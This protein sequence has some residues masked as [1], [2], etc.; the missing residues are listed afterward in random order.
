V[1]PDRGDDKARTLASPRFREAAGGPAPGRRR[2][3]DVSLAQG[4]Y[5]TGTGLWP[6]VSMSSFERVT[7]PKRD[8][9]LVKTVG[10][11]V[12]AIGMT[13]MRS[14]HR[15]RVHPD[16]ALLAGLSAAALAAIDI[17]N[18]VRRR[19]SPVYLVDALPEAWLAAW[20][21]RRVAWRGRVVPRAPVQASRKEGSAT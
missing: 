4:L 11:L 3:G 2:A 12:T 7:G 21:G 19:I 9:W 6:I 17:V 1:T 18:V 5:Y 14:G 13:L 16:V 20:W 15:N 8:H 10:V